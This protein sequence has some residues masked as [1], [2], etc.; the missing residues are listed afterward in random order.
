MRA[1]IQRNQ[2]GERHGR[3]DRGEHPVRARDPHGLP[4]HVDGDRIRHLPIIAGLRRGTPIL[5]AVES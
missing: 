5:A 3:P 4:R 2:Q 1:H